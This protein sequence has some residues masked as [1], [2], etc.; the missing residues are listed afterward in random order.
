MTSL[1]LRVEVKIE[2][3]HSGFIME[4]AKRV[5]VSGTYATIDRR[6]IGQLREDQ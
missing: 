3:H 2:L 5:L 6:E 4:Q 1:G